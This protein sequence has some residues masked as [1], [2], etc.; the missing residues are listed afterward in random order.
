MFDVH[1]GRLPGDVQLGPPLR[2]WSIPLLGD[3]GHMVLAQDPPDRGHGERD[4]IVPPK[5]E[6]QPRDPILPDPKDQR[7]DVRWGAKRTHPRP[8]QPG[9]QAR[10][11]VALVPTAPFVEKR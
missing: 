8:R 7:F 9:S 10:E 11:S 6:P 1:L 5:E 2:T 3:P 4:R